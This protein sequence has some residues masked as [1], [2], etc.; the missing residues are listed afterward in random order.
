MLWE[1]GRPFALPGIFLK[2]LTANILCGRL[3]KVGTKMSSWGKQQWEKMISNPSLS[4][5]LHGGSVPNLL[6]PPR[7]ESRG[8]RVSIDF[9]R[10]WASDLGSLGGGLNLN[11]S[12]G[13]WSSL[14]TVCKWKQALTE[15]L[16]KRPCSSSDEPQVRMY[17]HLRISAMEAVYCKTSIS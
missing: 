3:H 10:D 1:V 15:K 9:L 16:M 2:T 6:S 8:T 17:I 11:L 14:V 13:K 7:S 4:N 12:P 5:S